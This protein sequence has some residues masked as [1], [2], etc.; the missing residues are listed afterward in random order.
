[1]VEGRDN[2][3]GVQDL[4]LHADGSGLP[5]IHQK[6]GGSRN[7]PSQETVARRQHSIFLDGRVVFRD[8]VVRMTEVSNEILSRNELSVSDIDWFVPHQANMRIVET[9]GARLGMPKDRVLITLPKYG[10]TSAASIPLTLW[11]YE[12]RLKKGDRIL[13]AAFGGG[14]TWAGA[15]LIWAYDSVATAESRLEREGVSEP[16]E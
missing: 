4:V 10:N 12:N 16:A 2:G 11:D 6:A 15:Y 9:T 3:T 7:P 13:M 8:A 14:Y 5:Y 1:M